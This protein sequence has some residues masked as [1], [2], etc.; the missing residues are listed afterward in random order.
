M[1]QEENKEKSLLETAAS[2]GAESD[3]LETAEETK[4]QPETTLEAAVFKV[5]G[6]EQDAEDSDS[7]EETDSDEEIDEEEDD[8]IDGTKDPDEGPSDAEVVKEEEDEDEEDE[9]PAEEEGEESDEV[10]EEDE[11]EVDTDDVEV[12]AD[13]AEADMEDEVEDE[14]AGDDEGEE[15]DEES[16][17]DADSV[18][19]DEAEVVDGDSEEDDAIDGAADPDDDVSKAV[20]SIS[21]TVIKAATH[22]AKEKLN[23]TYGSMKEDLDALCAEDDTLSE[24]FKTKAAT[25]FEA[26]VTSKVNEHIEEIQESYVDYVNE[27]VNSLNEGL[28]DKI[29]SYLTYVAEQWIEKN[30]VAVT[31]VLRTEI[32]EAFMASLKENFESHYIEMPEGKTDMFD[33]VSQQNAELSE[34]IVTKDETISQLAEEVIS[35]K[36]EKIISDLSEGLADTQIGKFKKLTADVV[37]EDVDSF[38]EKVKV[39]R[40][41]YFNKKSEKVEEEVSE[42]SNSAT[43]KEVVVTEEVTDSSEELSPL[44]SRYVKAFTKL[45][46][47]AF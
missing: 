32:A 26:A 29:D 37:F 16:D 40:E 6:E 46:K 42:K 15:E 45:D 47:E 23:A 22:K 44:M 8:G 7:D 38:S 17:F 28:V 18:L 14:V 30:D 9:A 13:D 19:D 43:T 11:E 10:G 20:D 24:D 33:E 35:L 25:I 5:W 12:S 21:K 2:L 41:S 34:D 1:A 39:I 27:E 31:N 36:K 3:I 4:E